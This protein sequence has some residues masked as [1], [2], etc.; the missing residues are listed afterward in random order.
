MKIDNQK[1][2]LMLARQCKS[3]YFLRNA[4]SPQT[5]AKI[6]RG[7]EVNTS[8]VGRIARELGCDV[9]DILAKEET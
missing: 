2:E 5:L 8:T 9:T 4:V 6:R 3:M 1:L 7:S